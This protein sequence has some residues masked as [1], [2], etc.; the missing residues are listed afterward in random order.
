M[1]LLFIPTI[2]GILALITTAIISIGV[3]KKNS[4]DKKMQEIA[5][6]IEEGTMAFLNKEYKYLAVFIV[7]VFA[8]IAIFL[9]IRT[10]IA[11]LWVQY[12]L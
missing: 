8:A 12:F 9:D 6:H 10:A 3:V 7:V 1:K 2:C 4:G 11:F 5:S